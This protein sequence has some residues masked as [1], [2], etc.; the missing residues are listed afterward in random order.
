MFY[1]SF[2]KLAGPTR[3]SPCSFCHTAK[4]LSDIDGLFSIKR[5]KTVQKKRTRR[6]A[7][8]ST[9]TAANASSK[10][11]LKFPKDTADC[12]QMTK[13]KQETSSDPEEVTQP[14]W[15]K[16]QN[17]TEDSKQIAPAAAK[18]YILWSDE[19]KTDDPNDDFNFVPPGVVHHIPNMFTFQA[20]Y[21]SSHS[22]LGGMQHHINFDSSKIK[23]GH[24]GHLMPVTRLHFEFGNWL[25]TMHTFD[26]VNSIEAASKPETAYRFNQGKNTIESGC[27]SRGRTLSMAYSDS[28]IRHHNHFDAMHGTYPAA[29]VAAGPFGSELYHTDYI[30]QEAM[31]S[32]FPQNVPGGTSAINNPN[33]HSM[34]WASTAFD[35]STNDLQVSMQR[36]FQQ[37][38]QRKESF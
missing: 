22:I 27:W 16:M 34:S 4:T 26:R 18:S 21:V 29:S 19:A 2:H 24:A 8:K 15:C 5:L 12:P 17:P 36:G 37:W 10:P 3:M 30:R 31:Y 13:V 6:A 14:G 11:Q 20:D 28:G 35:V 1:F 23:V 25:P 33:D 38:L 7:N 9:A 32:S